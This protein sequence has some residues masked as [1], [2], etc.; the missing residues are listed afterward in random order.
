MDLGAGLYT[1]T[2]TDANGCT[3]LASATLEAP[4]A[5]NFAL[6][7]D[8]VDCGDTLVDAS[9]TASG[10]LSPYTI[11]LD[12]NVLAGSMPS[13]NAGL[14]TVQLL[15]A[16][17][18]SVD[19]S[20]TVTLPPSP[21]ISLPSDTTILLGNSLQIEATTNLSSWASVSWQPLPDSACANCLVQSWVPKDFQVITVTI[22]DTF[23]CSAQASIRVSVNKELALYVPNV[24]SPNNDG[25]NDVWTVNA[26]DSVV[27]ITEVQ[28]FDRWGNLQYA[29]DNS[30]APNAW[31]GWDGTTRGKQAQVGVYVYYLKVKLLDGSEEVVKGDVTV[32]EW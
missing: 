19:S 13:I 20:V 23:G 8:L 31:P 10:G 4:P 7:L 12:G 6:T 32:M 28:V 26:G 17:G 27:E 21:T 15:D 16:N 9:I 30:I 14:H 2:M 25:F 5:L 3:A 18:C 29:W 1:L 24:F 22:V 11:L